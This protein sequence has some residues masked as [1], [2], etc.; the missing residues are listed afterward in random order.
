MKTLKRKSTST[1]ECENKDYFNVL[2]FSC[3]R[4]RGGYIT[5]LAVVFSAVFVL[6]LS[7]LTG[8]IFVQHRLQIA[9]ENREQ[10]IQIAEAGL[11]YY[12]WFL[13]H[14]P[15]DLQDGTGGPGPYEHE[16]SDPEGGAIGKFSLEINGNLNCGETSSVSIN[17]T[18]WTYADPSLKREVF[19]KYARPSVAEYAYILNSSVWAGSDREIKGRYHSNGG[20]RMDG[21]NQ[22]TVTSA[23]EDWLCSESFGCDPPETKAGIF[24]S[25]GGFELWEFPVPPI[26]FVG[27]TVD[28][29][30]MK[31]RAVSDGVY[32]GSS[33]A[34]GYHIIL[35][36]DG[37][38][39]LYRVDN[40]SWV[41]S[42]HID[43]L[44]TW[45]RDYH[46][47]T[48]ETFLGNNTIPADCG[49]V[50][51]EDKLWLE[52]EVKGKLTVASADVTNPNVDTD[53]ILAGNI[54]YTTTDGSDGLTAIGEH[55]VLIPVQSPDNMELRGIFIAQKGYFGR[56][57]YPRWYE[58]Y[59]HRSTLEINGT[60]VS[61]GRVG[62]KWGCS[63]WACRDG[64][65]GY[66]SRE[67]SY[68]RKLATD[69]PPLTPYTSEEFKFVEWRE[70]N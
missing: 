14:F 13:A 63:V 54:N 58:P 29:V 59:D 64:W 15:D 53:L 40:T 34:Q 11:D 49:L 70:E 26:D 12:K 33:G 51:V 32:L 19:G 38:F 47:I 22:S 1:Q 61:N 66:N 30:N 65:S 68:D 41:W 36:N 46:T 56:N 69:P 2:L 67:N 10:A 35:K 50:F 62:T 21:E 28:L 60:I 44:S 37:T 4:A 42:I 7:S 43:D 20:I 39:D 17:S 27:L 45:Q 25:G 23:V 18:G 3:F 55:S 57:L 24:G 9:K 31:N 5:I 8:F 52:G 6:I 16:Y 48:S